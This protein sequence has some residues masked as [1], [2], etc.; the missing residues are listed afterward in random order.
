MPHG[1]EGHLDVFTTSKSADEAAAAAERFE[2]AGL[3]VRF[4]D[5]SALGDHLDLRDV[6]G[7]LLDPEGGTLDG[8]AYLR[9]MK[10]VL[11]NRGVDIY[12]NT[13]VLR[14]FEGRRIELETLSARVRAQAI[15]LATNAYTPHLGYFR[16]ELFPLHSHVIGTERRPPE[17]WKARGWRRAGSFTDDRDRLSY[18]TLS[19]SGRLVFGGGSNGAYDYV[20][21]NGTGLESASRRAAGA[22]QAQ[23]LDYLPKLDDVQVTH[24]WSGPIALT[25]SRVCTMGV[26]GAHR[27]V[28]FALGYSGHDVTLA[29]LAGKVL[30]DIYSDADERWRGLPF[31][32]QDLR[33]IPPEPFRWLGY[34]MYTRLTGRPPRAQY[35]AGG[36]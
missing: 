21:G 15:V 30:T 4:L 7:A 32:Q 18:G 2:S 24:R 23:L 36:S 13:Q 22:N 25:L 12:E 34:Q 27:N 28:Y 1:R 8:V 9:G 11:E 20:Y 26:R 33:F 10:A 19:A 29:N 3:P 16:S 17:D 31:Y 14:V 6:A 5:K 35:S